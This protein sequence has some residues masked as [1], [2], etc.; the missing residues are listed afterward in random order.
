P[1]DLSFSLWGPKAFRRTNFVHESFPS[2]WLIP[3]Q[4][5][6]LSP[7]HLLLSSSSPSHHPKCAEK[8]GC[9]ID[10]ITDLLLMLNRAA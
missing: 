5:S 2:R 7:H 6:P 3:N 9:G 10:Y 4:L 8:I 1:A